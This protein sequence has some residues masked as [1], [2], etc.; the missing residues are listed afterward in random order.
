MIYLI[1][2]IHNEE[3]FLERCLNSIAIQMADD[4]HVVLI[5]DGS[6]DKSGEIAAKYAEEWGWEL[7]ANETAEGPS[8]A[9][10]KGLDAISWT[11]KDSDWVAFLDSDDELVPDAFETMRE[12][13]EKW[14]FENII[15]FN[16]LRHYET[17]GKTVLK[18]FS[19]AGEYAISKLPVRWEFVWDKLYRATLAQSISFDERISYGEDELYNLD[20]LLEGQR[21][22][23]VED[24]T[25]KKHFENK[26]SIVHQLN[27]AQ[28]TK[29]DNALR[30]RLAAIT[31]RPY[32]P[33]ANIVALTRLIDEHRKSKTYARAGWQQ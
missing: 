3:P 29:Q 18:Y 24:I 31:A 20:M 14:G 2:P 12:A 33:W 19:S 32:E 4:I 26:N 22:R 9:R 28:C 15:Q 11:C 13:I 23:C 16:H 5:N 10:N 17:I 25:V 7:I 27:L 6:T 30:E 8:A 1:V 21:I